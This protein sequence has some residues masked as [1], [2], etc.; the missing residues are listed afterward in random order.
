MN[1]Y[2]TTLSTTWLIQVDL[3]HVPWLAALAE[4]QA[5][6][7]T[8]LSEFFAGVTFGLVLGPAYELSLIFTPQQGKYQAFACHV[9]TPP[10]DMNMT[11]AALRI[12][13]LRPVDL[14]QIEWLRLPKIESTNVKFTKPG[15]EWSTRVAEWYRSFAVP[16]TP[17]AGIRGAGEDTGPFTPIEVSTTART[18]LEQ[19][20]TVL[21]V[22]QTA[23]EKRASELRRK[24]EV[25]SREL[26]CPSCHQA[27][28]A[29]QRSCPNCGEA[30]R[31][32]LPGE[33][34]RQRSPSGTG[35]RSGRSIQFFPEAGGDDGLRRP[36]GALRRR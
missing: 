11:R 33:G 4:G 6:A 2:L 3:D 17:G 14:T 35:P 28:E 29:P 22:L 12:E 15:T 10:D 19:V 32:W 34:R 26:T 18:F 9:D 21:D 24:A 13:D 7:Y 8:F 25:V 23:R 36:R 5:H 1:R 20:D 27:M 16:G 30:A 31:Q